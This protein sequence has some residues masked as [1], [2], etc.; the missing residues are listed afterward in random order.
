MICC[1]SEQF[2]RWCVSFSL[3]EKGLLK[4]CKHLSN[5]WK[6]KVSNVVLK[7][8]IFTYFYQQLLVLDLADL[9]HSNKDSKIQ[10]CLPHVSPPIPGSSTHHFLALVPEGLQWLRDRMAHP[11]W[12]TSSLSTASGCHSANSLL[13]MLTFRQDYEN[14]QEC[15][16]FLNLVFTP[17][18]SCLKIDTDSH[19]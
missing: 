13:C 7:L 2:H 18:A 8:L 4:M 14:E 12:S 17:P 16:H 9:S 15:S 11:G 1:I 10:H 5:V 3:V 6:W 19:R